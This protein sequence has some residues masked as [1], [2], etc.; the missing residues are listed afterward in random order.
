MN[1]ILFSIIIPT[2]NRALFIEKTVQSVLRQTYENFEIIVVDDGSTDNTAEVIRNIESSKIKYLKID[3][4]ERG[5]A[6][7]Y[8]VKQSLG[9]YITFLDSD[10]ILFPDH[11][12]NAYEDIV[13]YNNPPFLHLGY[14]IVNTDDKVLFK[15][16]KLKNDNISFLIR[17]NSLSCNGCFLR[18]DVS[19]K[20]MFNEDRNLAGSEDWELWFRVLAANGIKVDNRVSSRM[21]NH[22]SRSV[23]LSLGQEKKLVLRKEL[24][25][26]YAFKDPKVK[27]VY[28]KYYNEIDAFG[29]SY[30]ALHLA[31]LGDKKRSIRFLLKFI[32]AYP[33][34]LFTKRFFVIIKCILS[35]LSK[36]N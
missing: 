13:K 19:R 12:S 29:D 32:T 1:N 17:G 16:D 21:Y 34:A 30:I 5:Y 14:E 26:Q 15:I 20:Y 3:N 27:E 23:S 4:S 33:L 36:K 9:D 11:F 18:A 8:G 2:Y 31:L 6:R 7:N 35:D 10:D 28:G 22:E 25:L 24:A